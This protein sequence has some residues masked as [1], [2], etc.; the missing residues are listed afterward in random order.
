MVDKSSENARTVTGVVVSDKMTDTIVVIVERSVKHPKYKK[1][2]KRSTKLKAHDAGNSASI[3]DLVV[4]AE[5]R[6]LSKTKAWN[7]V[8]IRE[9][10][11]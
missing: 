11:K 6:P 10:A 3:G 7:L 8:E 2:I 9:R 4:I 1:I 5:T